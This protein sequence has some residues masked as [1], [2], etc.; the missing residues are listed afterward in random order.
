MSVLTVVA[1]V[2]HRD[3]KILAYRRPMNKKL[4]G[5]WEFPGGKMEDGE[6]PEQA[7]ARELQEELGIRVQVGPVLDVL[8]APSEGKDVLLLF[9]ACTSDGEPK[10]LEGGTPMFVEPR[11]TDGM[12]FAPMDRIFLVR[13]G[14]SRLRGELYGK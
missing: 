14:L 12:D 13:G 7:L 9:Y 1:G 5:R 4:G 3:G 2:L 11:E 6:S 8:R 10:P